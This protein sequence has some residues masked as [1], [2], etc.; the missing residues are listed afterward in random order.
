MLVL[1]KSESIVE[2][3]DTE[4]EEASWR[5]EYRAKLCSAEQAVSVIGAGAC[6]NG[7]RPA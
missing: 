4:A 3:R 5:K 1:V 6:K 2:K 7:G